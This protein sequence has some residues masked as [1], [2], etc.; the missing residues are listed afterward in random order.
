M[1]G[2]A[3]SV[4]PVDLVP[5][6]VSRVMADLKARDIADRED[7]TPQAARLRA[8]SPEVGQ[9]LVTLALSGKKR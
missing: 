1:S 5:E 7:G 9:L 4:A 8:I 6:T 3:A 2:P